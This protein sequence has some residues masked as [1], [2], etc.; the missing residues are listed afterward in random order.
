MAA[1][2]IEK[3]DEP[4]QDLLGVA[5][6]LVSG[7]L[8]DDDALVCVYPKK[9]QSTRWHP[10]TRR[11]RGGEKWLT[12]GGGKEDVGVLARGSDGGDPTTVTLEGSLE[13]KRLGHLEVRRRYDDEGSGC[14]K[15]EEARPS[16]ILAEAKRKWT[17]DLLSPFLAVFSLS[18]SLLLV[19]PTT[20]ALHLFPMSADEFRYRPDP[21]Y[22]SLPELAQSFKLSKLSR[23]Y[24]AQFSNVYFS[25]LFELRQPATQKATEKWSGIKGAPFLL[26]WQRCL[27]RKE[28]ILAIVGSQ[29][30]RNWSNAFLMSRRIS[31]AT[32]SAPSTWTCLSSPTY[33]KTSQKT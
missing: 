4:L 3:K 24:A 15:E 1:G 7:E 5:V 16:Q 8:P 13:H 9:R 25:R 17:R 10:S 31:S 19:T 2:E 11:E 23:N 14:W 30:V 12:S 27:V 26:I 21:T 20:P 18:L 32:L 28:L 33:L 22:S 6:S 29:V